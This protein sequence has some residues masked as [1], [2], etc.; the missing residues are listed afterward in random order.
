MRRTVISILLISSLVVV[1]AALAATSPP[2]GGGHYKGS[3]DS[4][5]FY[6]T[7]N[8]VT[9]AVTKNRQQFAQGRMYFVLQGRGGLGSCAGQAYV[10]LSPSSHRQIT[11]AGT[12]DLH[13]HFTF[14]V[15]TPYG[16]QAYQTVV[17]VKGAF[18]D[19]GKQVG[20]TLNETASHKS[21]SCH[22]GTVHF[23]AALTK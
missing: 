5:T 16:P 12:F 22:S 21:F 13:G 7:N 18:S 23:T 19:A 6:K 2:V 1:S 3:T 9:L 8:S 11:P 17:T 10:T 20:G 15:A 14:S 4:K